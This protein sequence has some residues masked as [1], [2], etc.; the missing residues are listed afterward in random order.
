M[1]LRQVP[2]RL[3]SLL[4]PGHEGVHDGAVAVQAEDECHVDRDALRQDPADRRETLDRGRDLDHDVGQAEQVEQA[5]RLED[6]LVGVDGTHDVAGVPDVGG[7]QG[8]HRPL[9]VR[10]LGDELLDLGRV[11]LALGQGRR[12]DRGVGG[13]PHDA[14]GVDDLLQVAGGDALSG[15]VVQPDGDTCGREGLEVLARHTITCLPGARPGRRTRSPGPWRRSRAP[16]RRGWGRRTQRSRP[17]RRR[18]R[19][20]A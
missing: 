13:D 8:E 11:L 12:E 6:G 9:H 17:W 4:H 3:A 10:A 1:D 7:G 5:G 19:P 15:Q 20:P 14:L 16:C 18:R 2:T